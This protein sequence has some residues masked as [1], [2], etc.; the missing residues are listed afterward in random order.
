LQQQEKKK[1]VCDKFFLETQALERSVFGWEDILRTQLWEEDVA[2]SDGSYPSQEGARILSLRKRLTAEE[3]DV[4][5]AVASSS[6]TSY[7]QS[8]IV[9]DLRHQRVSY[10][11]LQMRHVHRIIWRSPGQIVYDI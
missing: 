7:I 10:R 9:E 8:S 4:K 5:D 3:D 11:N 2:L 6:S 1:E